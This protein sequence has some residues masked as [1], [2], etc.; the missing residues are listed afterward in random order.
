MQP[1]IPRGVIG[2]IIGF[3]AGFAIVIA[4]RIM[5]G[6]EPYWKLGLGI[7]LAT[8]TCAFGFVWGMGA[9]DAKM[10]AHPDDSIPQPTLEEQARQAGPL[11]ILTNTTWSITFW[12]LLVVL[13]VF[14]LAKIP[15]VGL[16]VTRIPNASVSEI[17]TYTL[18]AFGGE[19]VVNQLVVLAGFIAFTMF[20]LFMAAGAIGFLL[21]FL[22][23]EVEVSRK[24][25]NVDFSKPAENAPALLQRVASVAGNLAERIDTKPNTTT[26]AVVVKKEDN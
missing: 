24:T 11:G 23:Q 20:S 25:A 21:T 8:F 12:T 18:Q 19:I 3:L 10:S 13:G 15:G 1:G 22:N 7:V 9:F 6:F 14:A 17:G 5:F 4:L 16:T 26:T 2:G